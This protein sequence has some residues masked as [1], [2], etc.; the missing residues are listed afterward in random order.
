MAAVKPVAKAANRGDSIAQYN[1]AYMYE[2]GEGIEKDIDQAIY[3]YKKAAE[4]GDKE[5]QKEL[6][7][8]LRIK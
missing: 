3:W 4:Q 1:L 5:A 6:K 7:K 8:I 2:N